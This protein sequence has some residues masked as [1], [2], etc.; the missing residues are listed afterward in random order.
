MIILLLRLM[1]YF[2]ALMDNATETYGNSVLGYWPTIVYSLLPIVAGAIYEYVAILLN[3]FECHP[4]PVSF[5]SP[6][7]ILICLVRWMRS[8]ISS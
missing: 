1:I 7:P 4:T 8:T 6:Q 2:I 3:N 5:S